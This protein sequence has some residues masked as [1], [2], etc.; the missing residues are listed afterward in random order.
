METRRRN[1][2]FA[3]DTANGRSWT[4]PHCGRRFRHANQAH[5][6]GVFRVEDVLAGAPPSVGLLFRAIE[7]RARR[8][9]PVTLA[10]TKTRIGLQSGTL[11]GS[12]RLGRNGAHLELRLPQREEHPRFTRVEEAQPGAWT[13]HLVVRTLD[14]LT[15]EV[16]RWICAAHRWGES[17]DGSP[18]APAPRSAA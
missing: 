1:A 12:V 13:H 7:D 18:P 14:D 2:V 15:P 3:M 10:P 9:G 11:F 16:D 6:C 8:C 5:S 17:P 4:C